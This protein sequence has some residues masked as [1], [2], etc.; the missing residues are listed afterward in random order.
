M[1]FSFFQQIGL[2]EDL[3]KPY[4]CPENKM[5]ER[6]FS[7]IAK[8]VSLL[9]HSWVGFEEISAKLGAISHEAFLQQYPMYVPSDDEFNV[10]NHGDMWINNFLFKY[11]ASGYPKEIQIVNDFF[12]IVPKLIENIFNYS[13]S[14]SISLYA[15]SHRPLMICLCYCMVHRTS[16][17]HKPTGMH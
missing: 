5:E 8:T 16:V 2:F 17:S 7:N 14:R 15:L 9:S 4:Y 6:F 10:L 13:N 12:F 1:L 11:D 3:L